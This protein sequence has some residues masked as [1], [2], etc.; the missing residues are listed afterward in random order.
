MSTT[1]SRDRMESIWASIQNWMENTDWT[2]PDAADR[3]I[4][5]VEDQGVDKFIDPLPGVPFNE[6]A[7]GNYESIKQEFGLET[8]AE[9]NVARQDF[10][11]RQ[12]R[13]A[14]DEIE[15][16]FQEYGIQAVADA[17]DE[18]APPE[19]QA[20][21]DDVYREFGPDYYRD[22]AF[23]EIGRVVD[24][25]DIDAELVSAD[26]LESLQE[27]AGDA[28]GS[29][30]EQMRRAEREVID[31]I[32][33]AFG[34]RF[35]SVDDAITR[36]RDRIDQLQDLNVRSSD[37]RLRGN[38]D[39]PPSVTVDIGFGQFEA[40][41]REQVDEAI[42]RGDIDV[43]NTFEK[44]I[45]TLRVVDDAIQVIDL[46]PA[47]LVPEVVPA[48]VDDSALTRRFE[49]DADVAVPPEPEVS[50]PTAQAAETTADPEPDDT[51]EPDDVQTAPEPDTDTLT[52]DEA[53]VVEDATAAW[54]RDGL[55][56]IAES[57]D[58]PALFTLSAI[59]S[60]DDLPGGFEDDL[61]DSYQTLGAD[62]RSELASRR[63]GMAD[64]QR[65]VIGVAPDQQRDFDVDIEID[66][67][68]S[69]LSVEPDPDD[70]GGVDIPDAE[71]GVA[72]RTP[73][74]DRQDRASPPPGA[75]QSDPNAIRT[76]PNSDRPD[77][78]Q[79]DADSK[80][81]VLLDNRLVKAQAWVAAEQERLARDF[82]D[83][84]QFW[85]AFGDRVWGNNLTEDEFV[86]L[87]AG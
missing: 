11:D 57:L 79:T 9:R 59:A 86:G 61:T 78:N 30:A 54:Q 24:D 60:R 51:D 48:I 23:N 38:R 66:G 64:L 12:K 42:D 50:D 73:P 4:Q 21:F 19:L 47:T 16:Q 83:P 58:T 43:R 22:I 75:G 31:R 37:V 80:I 6:A 13:A 77:P 27:Q 44:R 65:A 72:G 55:T 52:D 33:L 7:S 25:F 2:D 68:P 81:A 84:R 71:G 39:A 1:P 40:R 46:T 29:T 28:G 15:D 69:D 41:V 63:D 76:Q 53:A 67:D 18:R 34:Q 5:S 49:I 35:D 82:D 17:F 36:L 62:E 45:G 85:R 74:S 8:G 10:A 3:V 56:G 20:R 14:V 70:G 32:E 87:T 26:R